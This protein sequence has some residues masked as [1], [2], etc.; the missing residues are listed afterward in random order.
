[1]TISSILLL[2]FNIFKEKRNQTSC[3]MAFRDLTKQNEDKD[4][5]IFYLISRINPNIN[6]SALCLE[7]DITPFQLLASFVHPPP[8]N[9]CYCIQ[10][11]LIIR[12]LCISEFAYSN[13][14]KWSKMTSFLSIINFLSANSRFAVLTEY[15]D[16]TYLPRIT[17]EMCIFVINYSP[18]TI[19][20]VLFF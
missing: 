3:S 17:R 10:V 5:K 8:L 18:T 4:K 15:N 14:Q 1:M 6:K 12:G 20:F 16:R 13:W 7:Y 11:V 9:E 19:L 2:T